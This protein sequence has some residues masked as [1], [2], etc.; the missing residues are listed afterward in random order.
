MATVIMNQDRNVAYPLSLFKLRVRAHFVISPVSGN[1]LSMGCKLWMDCN[2][3]TSSK[4]EGEYRKPRIDVESIDL[5]DFDTE[6][7]AEAERQ[8]IRA[9]VTRGEKLIKVSGFYGDD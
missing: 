9:C 1:T 3:G 5:G 4:I 6:E 2:N 8:R 7:E